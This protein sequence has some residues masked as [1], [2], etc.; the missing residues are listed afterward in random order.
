MLHYPIKSD[1]NGHYAVAPNADN[2]QILVQLQESDGNGWGEQVR[3]VLTADE[4]RHMIELL[5]EAVTSVERNVELF[6]PK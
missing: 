1:D 6:I 3:V 4:A 2:K 5:N